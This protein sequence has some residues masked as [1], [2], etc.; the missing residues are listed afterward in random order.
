[1]RLQRRTRIKFCGLTSVAEI[2][3]AVEA[4]ADAIGV[5]VAESPRQV[6]VA[7]LGELAAAV[8]AFVA[9]V[10]VLAA[11]GQREAAALRE[12]GYMLQFS[13]DEPAE[14][15]ERLAAGRYL[16]AFHLAPG[17]KDDVLDDASLAAYRNATWMFDSRV[18][19]RYGGTGVPFAWK[20]VEAAAAVRPVIVSGGLT[21]ENVAA[22]VRSVRPYAVDV[23]SGIET[24]GRKD[25]AKMLAFVRAVREADEAPTAA[26]SRNA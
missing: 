15:C 12:L 13:G 23:R 1:M 11:Q 24:A 19:A 3:L 6:D 22:C 7:R 18:D 9:K 21:P 17:Q 2:A 25:P 14:L 8:P 5:I 20:L 10:G 26:L 16:K 4:G